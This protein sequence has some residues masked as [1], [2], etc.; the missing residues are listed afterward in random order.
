MRQVRSA[1]NNN[2]GFTLLEMIVT[3]A[4]VIVVI[5]ITGSAFESILKTSARIS[6]SEE[7]NIEGVV[8][9]EMFR[10][11]LQQMGYGLPHAFQS[12]PPV[13][14]EASI[15]PANKLNDA[16][17]GVPRA[18]ASWE[19]LSGA[20]DA[21]SETG[22]TYNVLNNTDYL[23]IKAASVG[24]TKT[25]QRWTYLG[26]SSGGKPANNWLNAA[27]NLTAS[28]SRVIVL[29]RTFS[30][31]GA[32]TNNLVYD[33]TD[34]TGTY[35]V[36]YTKSLFNSAYSPTDPQQTYYLYGI[37]NGDLG[38]PFNRADF[39]VARPS[40]AS[41]VP[42]T[43]ASGTGIL[44]KANINHADGKLTYYPLLDCVADMQVVFGWDINS[45]GV[46][47]ESSAYDSN[48]NNISVSSTI[49]TTAA[50]IKAIMENAEDIRNKLKYIKVYIMAQEGR[51]DTNYTNTNNL[52]NN[53]L[54]VVVGE[55]GPSPSSNVSLTKG[56]TAAALTSS[57]WLNYRWKIYKLVVRPKNLAAN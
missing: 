52:I 41:S 28:T 27:D 6:S 49:G 7:S 40:T 46:I 8:G 33:T 48:S 16:P 36:N 1:M 23:S 4:L 51:K 45:N 25:S 53:T 18:V 38:M 43:C 34:N 50:A 37:A 22:N 47:D 5:M 13:Y 32:A 3:M 54:S 12:T 10:R 56:Y 29:N 17:S 44:Y 14:T 21:S 20:S 35:W 15:A 57:G 11:D 19:S 55:P 31:T 39:F 30:T 26:Y 24:A 2:R 42:T 9:L